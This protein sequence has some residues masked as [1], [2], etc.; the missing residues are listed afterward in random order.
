M[1]KEVSIALRFAENFAP[2]EGTIAAHRAIIDEKGSVWY[3]KLGSAISDKNTKLIL[4]SNEPR[5]LLIHSGGVERYWASIDKVSRAVPDL[6]LI[7]PYC[8][9]RTDEFGCWFHVLRI[10]EAPRNE[11]SRWVVSSSGKL[12]TEASRHSM[13]PYFVIE[14]KRDASI[15]KADDRSKPLKALL[16]QE[17]FG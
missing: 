5:L 6:E 1:S 7:P 14:P 9:K 13:S 16:M 12:L 10:E 2:R 11:M 4:S 15:K 3:G 8:R 17:R